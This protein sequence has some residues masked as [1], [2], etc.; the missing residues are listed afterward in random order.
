MIKNR[1]IFQFAE[2][3]K[4]AKI[5]LCIVECI[6]LKVDLDALV[7]WCTE[8]Q[9]IANIVKFMFMLLCSSDIFTYRPSKIS[10]VY[11]CVVLMHLL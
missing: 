2:D 9:F 4:L 10:V 7:K 3:C 6:L 5:I 1:A 11:I 8:W